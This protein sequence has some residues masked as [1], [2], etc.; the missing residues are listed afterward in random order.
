MVGSSGPLQ[1]DDE[2][3]SVAKVQKEQKA[4]S[5]VRSQPPLEENK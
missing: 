3:V 4:V 5:A 2:I 1:E